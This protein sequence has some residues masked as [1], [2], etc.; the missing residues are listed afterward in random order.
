MGIDVSGYFR[1]L[2][3]HTELQAGADDLRDRR[4]TAGRIRSYVDGIRLWPRVTV[5]NRT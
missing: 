5:R 1:D 3:N 2:L 4:E